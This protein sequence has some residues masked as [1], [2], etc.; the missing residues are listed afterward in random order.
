MQVRLLDLGLLLV[1]N[2]VGVA[3]MEELLPSVAFFFLK[4]FFFF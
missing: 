2:A 1:F 3:H 4:Y